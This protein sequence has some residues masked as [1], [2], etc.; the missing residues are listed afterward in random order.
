MRTKEDMRRVLA[1]ISNDMADDASRFNGQPFNGKTVAEY[2]G[3]MGAAVAAVAEILA[4]VIADDP[5]VEG[6]GL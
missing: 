1:M 2:L 3:S 5:D 4:E 6:N